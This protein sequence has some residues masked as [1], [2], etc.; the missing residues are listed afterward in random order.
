[1][2]DSKSHL[3]VVLRQLELL[4]KIQPGTLDL[5]N[6]AFL[7]RSAEVGNARDKVYALLGLAKDTERLCY[8]EGNI[9][10]HFQVS[11]AKSICDVYISAAKAMITSGGLYDVLAEACG[12]EPSKDI[13]PTWVPNW[14]IQER[15]WDAIDVTSRS[16]DIFGPSRPKLPGYHLLSNLR[17]QAPF[18]L[19][20]ETLTQ[21]STLQIC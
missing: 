13:L 10:H 16:I 5:L 3:P 12:L 7:A 18:P 8:P 9:V 21:Y 17:T 1:M 6:L 2:K 11:Y 15:S 14:S 20:L 4:R 19:Q